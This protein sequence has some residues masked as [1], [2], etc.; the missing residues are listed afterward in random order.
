[1]QD[2]YGKMLSSDA[3]KFLKYLYFFKN[4]HSDKFLGIFEWLIDLKISIDTL[5]GHLKY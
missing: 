1:M 2:I 4:R 3:A 5:K